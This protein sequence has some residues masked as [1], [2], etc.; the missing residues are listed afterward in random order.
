MFLFVVVLVSQWWQ[1]QI[2]TGVSLFFLNLINKVMICIIDCSCS[3]QEWSVRMVIGSC[4]LVIFIIKTISKSYNKGEFFSR[5]HRKK[6]EVKNPKKTQNFLLL[7][8]SAFTPSLFLKFPSPFPLIVWFPLEVLWLKTTEWSSNT[9]ALQCEEEKKKIVS[10][11]WWQET[12][13][14]SLFFFFCGTSC[15]YHQFLVLLPSTETHLKR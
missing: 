15:S 6:K 5:R 4:D 1:W 9:Q 13:N 10:W 12:S 11:L 3:S 7:S 2:C 8:K 14:W